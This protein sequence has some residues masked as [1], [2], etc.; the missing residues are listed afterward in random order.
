[1]RHLGSSESADGCRR[2]KR[3]IDNIAGNAILDLQVRHQ[4]IERDAFGGRREPV[5][6][7]VWSA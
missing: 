6:L 7:L 3:D 5:C 4:V 1:M 2:R